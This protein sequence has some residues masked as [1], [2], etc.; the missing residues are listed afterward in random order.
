PP[1]KEEKITI[2]IC[3]IA[4]PLLVAGHLSSAARWSAVHLSSAPLHFGHGLRPMKK[5]KGKFV[6]V[7]AQHKFSFGFFRTA[8]C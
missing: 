7:R 6:Y 5:A 3:S 2:S 8:H 4:S 1:Q